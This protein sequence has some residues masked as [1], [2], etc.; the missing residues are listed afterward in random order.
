VGIVARMSVVCNHCGGNFQ[1]PITIGGTATN[2]N[3]KDILMSNDIMLDIE[4]LDSK[5]DCV[6]LTI[7]A[8]RFKLCRRYGK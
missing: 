7:G 4:S 8:V 1:R 6:V 2:V 3:I 5:F